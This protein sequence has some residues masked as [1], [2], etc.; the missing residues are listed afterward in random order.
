MI[1]RFASLPGGKNGPQPCAPGRGPGARH[2]YRDVLSGGKVWLPGDP[3]RE[4][5]VVKC[6]HCS[7]VYHESFSWTV[8]E[9][10]DVF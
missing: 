3:P 2:V 10:V 5:Y 8:E 4:A 9:E 6:M 1:G 7:M